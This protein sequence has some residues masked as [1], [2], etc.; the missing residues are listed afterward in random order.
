MPNI[1]KDLTSEQRARLFEAQ[2]RILAESTRG[3]DLHGCLET[4]CRE[5]EALLEHQARCTVLLFDGDVAVGTVAPS[6]PKSYGN[7]L[8]GFELGPEAGS[9]GTAAYR[10]EETI[11]EDI[12][13]SRLWADYQDLAADHGLVAC[14]SKPVLDSDG[15]VLATFGVYPEEGAKPSFLAQ[16]VIDTF[17]DLAG[18]VISRARSNERLLS[19]ERRLDAI[20]KGTR[21]AAWEWDLT[22]NHIDVTANWFDILGFSRSD[23]GRPTLDKFLDLVHPSDLEMVLDDIQAHLSGETDVFETEL[24]MRHRD[25]RWVWLMNRGQIAERTE[26]GQPAIVAGMIVDITERREREEELVQSRELLARTGELA[27]IGGW[28]LETST[29]NLWISRE[30]KRVLGVPEHRNPDIRRALGR[31]D[32]DAERHEVQARIKK[33]VVEGVPYKA[34]F[35]SRREDGTQVRILASGQPILEDGEVVRIQGALQDITEQHRAN[36]EL[37]RMRK[38][39]SL[40]RLAGGIAHDFNNILMGFFANVAFAKDSLDAG[41]P[42]VT[43]L[44]EAEKALDRAKRLTGQLLTFA[45]GGAPMTEAVSLDEIVKRVVEFDLTGSSVKPV[46]DTSDDLWPVEV[47]IGQIQQVFSNLTI[48]AL[49]AVDGSGKLWIALKNCHLESNE[50]IPL[51]AGRYIKAV[52]RDDGPGID[53]DALGRIFDPYYTEKSDGRGL[54]LATVFSIV[55]KHGGHIAVTSS[56]DEGAEFTLYL[57]AAPSDVESDAYLRPMT[58]LEGSEAILSRELR[59]LVV[60]DEEPVRRASARLLRA[61]GY[62]VSTA[63]GGKPAL[64]MYREAMGTDDSFDLVLTDITIPGGMGGR[65]LVSKLYEIDPSV[66]AIASSGYADDPVL[67]EHR[68]YG[69]AAIA[70]KPYSGEELRRTIQR[71]FM[72]PS[73]E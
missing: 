59:I 20:V 73:A 18:L 37:Q 69:F 54:G 48:N 23:A 56:S 28:F 12:Q 8:E 41:H 14:W 11:V 9:C 39:D 46:F 61:E 7:A 3:G 70:P 47:D 35:T 24:R 72:S 65:E 34:S 27:K 38:L 67:A 2:S 60:D 19:K 6:L 13:S 1:S 25:D 36:E 45:K 63:A 58:P 21:A 5:V 44:E 33:S 64:E 68:K 26:E 16:A 32:S 43:D 30:G 15:R 50:D 42:A 10:K 51:A 52:V 71:A 66:R 29:N 40:G 49:E 4:L 57:P 62:E 53:Q 31:I 22:T 17:T 55:S